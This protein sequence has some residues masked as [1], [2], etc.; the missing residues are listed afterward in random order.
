MLGLPQTIDFFTSCQRINGDSA[1]LP[2]S[3][4]VTQKNRQSLK[5]GGYFPL[6]EGIF[7]SLILG[8]NSIGE[9][10]CLDSY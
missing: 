3:V 9:V 5:I 1:E 6:L 7:R 4:M 8:I 2:Y 10:I